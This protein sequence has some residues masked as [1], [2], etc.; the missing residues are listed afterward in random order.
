MCLQLTF[1]KSN[2]EFLA[3]L[4]TFSALIRK[5]GI[6]IIL[7]TKHKMKLKGKIL[8]QKSNPKYF[9]LQYNGINL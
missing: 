3:V 8:T 4:S 2:T 1:R 5:I 9:H 6:N 7:Q